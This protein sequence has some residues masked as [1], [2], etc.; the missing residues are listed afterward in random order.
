MKSGGT[1]PLETDKI[2]AKCP[3]L[4]VLVVGK[5]G[6]GKS[7]LINHVFGIKQQVVS[8]QARGV[9]N[10]DDEI[11]SPDNSRLILHDSMGFEPGQATNLQNAI[12]FLK[13]RSAE[14]VA[15]QDQVHVVWLCIK[16]PHAGG[17]VLETGDE[18]FIESALHQKVPLII[19]FTQ[20]DK[21][22]SL[23]EQE[24]TD[25]EMDSD[26]CDDIVTQR[27]AT[28]FVEICLRPLERFDS[29]RYAQTSGKHRHI[30]LIRRGRL[31]L[32]GCRSGSFEIAG[33]SYARHGQKNVWYVTAVAQRTSARAKVDGSIKIGMQ[34]YW[35]G[36]ASTTKL[37]G[38]PLQTCLKTIHFEITASWNFNDP[39]ELLTNG[40]FEQRLYSLIQFIV[41]EDKEIRSWFDNVD[42]FQTL[43]GIGTAITAAAAPALAAIGLSTMFIQWIGDIYKKTPEA[44]RCL[45]AYM[46]DLTLIMDHL[47]LKTLNLP[48]PRRL[49]QEDIDSA[50]ES[51]KNSSAATVHK[52]VR[53]YAN[54]TT[55]AQIVRSNNAEEK[56]KELINLHCSK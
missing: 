9:C 11:T 56:V 36:L 49:T 31:N 45:M 4:R 27:S 28:K 7:S 26:E 5:S 30:Q 33:R 21:L 55:I 18:K 2:L 13:A 43:M 17:R 38:S 44:L 3:R 10:I 16:I 42:P 51:Y 37:F 54:Q 24:L 29:V 46:C 15:I 47:F 23:V 50:V 53:M 41:P 14:H 52:E 32:H 12:A 1:L 22:K 25:E 6:T 34:G 39:D 19:V 48:P 35:L 8:H 20:F 40:A